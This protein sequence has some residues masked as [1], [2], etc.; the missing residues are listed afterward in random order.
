MMTILGLG[1]PVF[2]GVVLF[3]RMLVC[4]AHEPKK[5]KDK[6]DKE[7]T[8]DEGFKVLLKNPE[9]LDKLLGRK[10]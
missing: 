9:Y 4:W 5:W 2:I 6:R 7:E 3:F 1:L 8:V 10:K